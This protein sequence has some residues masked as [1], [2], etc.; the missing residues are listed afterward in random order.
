MKRDRGRNRLETRYTKL[1]GF[2]K[3]PVH[4]S[5]IAVLNY[6]EPEGGKEEGGGGGD[7]IPGGQG[8]DRITMRES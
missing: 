8:E 2:E 3:V 1:T 5:F 6:V 4:V 7:R